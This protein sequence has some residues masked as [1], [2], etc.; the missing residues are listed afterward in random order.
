M[1]RGVMVMAAVSAMSLAAASAQSQVQPSG[2]YAV[3]IKDLDLSRVKDKEAFDDRV[4]H[5]AQK[6][7]DNHGI[8]RRDLNGFAKCLT[9]V[10]E[11]ANANLHVVLAHQPGA[12]TVAVR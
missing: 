8:E 2:A 10:H 12:A 11:E 3:P 4:D 9:A 7:C 6:I 1:L 5:V